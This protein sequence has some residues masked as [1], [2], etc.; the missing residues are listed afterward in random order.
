MPPILYFHGFG[1]SPESAKVVALKQMLEPELE[2]NAPDMNAPSFE[3]LDFEAMVQRAIDEAH[4]L[5][6]RA[7]VGSSVGSLVALELV[8]RGVHAPLVL[9]APA[10]GVAERWPSRLPAGDPVEVFNHARNA[11]ARIHRAFFDRL[12]LQRPEADAPAVPVTIVMG[13]NDESVPFRF[14]RGVWETWTESQK[15][16]PGSKFIEIA[17]GD[18]SLVAHAE[19]IAREIRAAVAASSRA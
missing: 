14:V 9:I 6:P 12:A 4:R 13:R 18:H 8:R 10:V 19:L 16:V 15:L 5:P 2:V 17:G 1:S 3:R 7:I 11:N